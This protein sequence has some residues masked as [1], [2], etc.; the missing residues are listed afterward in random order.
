MDMNLPENDISQRL[1]LAV[2]IAREAGLITLEHFRDADL[3]VERKADGSP[4]TVADRRAE[5]HLRAR[6]S[7]A[8]ADDAILGE[9]FSD[10]PGNS[11][12]R[13][14]LDPIDGTKSFIHGV[15][16]F[17]T[18]VAV[19]YQDR[20]VLGVIRLPA[21][22]Q[23][24]YAAVGRGTW[25]VEGKRPPRAAKVSACDELRE[26][27]FLTSE[28]ETFDEIDRRDAYFKLQDAARLSRTW[29]DSYGYFLV[30]TG[31]AEVMVDPVVS[32]WDIA[33]AMPII[34]EAGGSFSDWDGQ[35]THRSGN[36]IA[37]N[38]RLHEA[39]LAAIRE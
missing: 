5:E 26:S 27:L 20:P 24:V 6:I 9:E 30:A 28:V 15:P 12:F 16:L 32:V 29:G 37:T 25:L 1:E 38:G 13:W 17:G 21:L 3:V 8:F 14:V 2:E 23:G 33:A 36:A 18:L 7:E 19:E 10:R 4:V 35:R 22:D 11:G 31:R 34:E 39:V